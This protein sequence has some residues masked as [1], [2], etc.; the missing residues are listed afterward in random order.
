MRASTRR[1]RRSCGLASVV[2][3]TA[4]G[5]R[6]AC[7]LVLGHH[8]LLL[9]LRTQ[10]S[11]SPP[12]NPSCS[13]T[14]EEE[15]PRKQ[16][17]CEDDA[18]PESAGRSWSSGDDGEAHLHDAVLEPDDERL[19]AT[20]TRK[21]QGGVTNGDKVRSSAMR[22]A[23]RHLLMALLG[24]FGGRLRPSDPEQRL[25]DLRSEGTRLRNRSVFLLAFQCAEEH[26]VV[27]RCLEDLLEIIDA[28]VEVGA[29]GHGSNMKV[30]RTHRRTSDGE[31]AARL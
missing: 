14:E 22:A 7:E 11:R 25:I 13:C 17:R 28:V 19:E 3:R 6:T 4:S 26:R 10:H 2:R 18:N 21:V 23:N 27:P 31:L 16:R 24:S 12:S 1:P 20:R 8:C 5:I 15:E 29:I 30:L 9:L